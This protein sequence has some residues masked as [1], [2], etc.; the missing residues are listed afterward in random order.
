MRARPVEVV[1]LATLFIV[2]GFSVAV[3]VAAD[4]PAGMAGEGT[5]DDPYEITNATQ[6]QAIEDDL[7]AHYELVQNV[8]ADRAAFVPIGNSTSPFTGS[9]DGQGHAVERLFIDDSRDSIPSENVGLFGNT[10]GARIENVG[11]ED[12]TISGQSGVGALIGVADD[13]DVSNV[14]IGQEVIVSGDTRFGGLIGVHEG[15]GTVLDSLAICDIG[16]RFD[17]PDT[18]GRLIGTGSGTVTDSYYQSGT[19]DHDMIGV[20]YSSDALTGSNSVETL[21]FD[22]DDTWIATDEYPI[23]QGSVDDYSLQVADEDLTVGDTTIVTVDL[24]RPVVFNEDAREPA[25]ITTNENVSIDGQTLTAE[26]GGIGTVMASASGFSNDTS[27]TITGP[28]TF[29]ISSA[30]F[31]DAVDAGTNLSQRQRD[32]HGDADRWGDQ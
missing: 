3:P 6:L 1:L 15:S 4:G 7:D 9:F 8:D 26:R 12:A 25:T 17:D 23:L 21:P 28:P 14:Y 32:S 18:S 31:P 30:A 11:I 10:S 22:F 5:V 19:D 29:E 24:I 13:T 16:C 20:G 2:A 27:V